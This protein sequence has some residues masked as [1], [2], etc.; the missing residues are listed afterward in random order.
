MKILADFF[1]ALGNERRLTVFM[2]LHEHGKAAVCD[3]AHELDISEQATSSHLKRLARV[4]LI[5][6][7][8]AGEVVL[9]SP[10]RR[11]IKQP[12]N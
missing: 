8:R 4:G 11:F 6:Q 7:N 12:F 10:A 9:S 1:R 5:E 3:L 2:Y